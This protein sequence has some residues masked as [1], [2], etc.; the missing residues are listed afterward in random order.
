MNITSDQ[1]ANEFMLKQNW[2]NSN[3]F[4][5]VSD[6]RILEFKNNLINIASLDMI[7]CKKDVMT[8]LN[9]QL[10]RLNIDKVKSKL[11]QG[12]NSNVIMKDMKCVIDS[13]FYVHPSNQYLLFNDNISDLIESINCSN[14]TTNKKFINNFM[15]VKFRGSKEDMFYI[16]IVDENR[17]DTLLNEV[18]MGIYIT[19]T[20][21]SFC[22]NFAYVYGAF[23]KDSNI[24]NTKKDTMSYILYENLGTD[25]M[26]LTKFINRQC[27]AEEFFNMFLQVTFALKEANK[28]NKYTHYN[29]HTDNVMIRKLSRSISIP[30][31]GISEQLY[32]TTSAIATI[33]DYSYSF[34]GFMNSKTKRAYYIGNTNH[35]EYSVYFNKSHYYHDIYKLLMYSMYT[36]ST[37]NKQVYDLCTLMFKFF[38]KEDPKRALVDQKPYRYSLPY[39]NI[40]PELFLAFLNRY[41]GNRMTFIKGNIN[42]AKVVNE[43]LENVFKDVG[44]DIK[45]PNIIVTPNTISDFI[46]MYNWYDKNEEM[47][48]KVKEDFKLKYYN[49]SITYLNKLDERIAQFNDDIFNL[50]SQ[51]PNIDNIQTLSDILDDT[52]FNNIKYMYEVSSRIICKGD[53]ILRRIANIDKISLIYSDA[54]LRQQAIDLRDKFNYY[55]GN[56]AEVHIRAVITEFSSLLDIPE[57]RKYIES[58]MKDDKFMWYYNERKILEKDIM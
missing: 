2:R 38:S 19:N 35:Y 18:L 57:N 5:E 48:N 36:A 21:R 39:I 29:L 20:F 51:F 15:S 34:G 4:Q 52:T 11:D 49:E 30:Y 14:L 28:R 3:A 43:P 45:A 6:E 24:I 25:M 58:N 37:T 54:N 53:N 22:P 33:V 56:N 26:T 47:M 44:V 17:K 9:N 32:I 16:K 55:I 23:N 50:V 40:K 13:L 7:K 27:T 46:S 42:P 31:V 10:P 1:I 8:S 41:L 12:Y